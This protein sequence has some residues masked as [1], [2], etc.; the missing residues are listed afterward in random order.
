MDRASRL[1]LGAMIEAYDVLSQLQA[2]M[3]C[4]VEENENIPVLRQFV[5]D[6]NTHSQT[7]SY[8]SQH[9]PQQTEDNPLPV[10]EMTADKPVL[11]NTDITVEETL[12]EREG[13]CHGDCQ[14][15]G[16]GHLPD[17]VPAIRSDTSS[18]PDLVQHSNINN[19]HCKT[20][21]ISWRPKRSRPKFRISKPLEVEKV[22]R[23]QTRPNISWKQAGV[24]L[25]ELADNFSSVELSPEDRT[26]RQ[27]RQSVD[28]QKT[29]TEH[30][31]NNVF[32]C[33]QAVGLFLIMKKI[34]KMLK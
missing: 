34:D 9:P 13:D 1:L 6:I 20:P 14:S 31:I 4:E 19:S 28:G 17:I 29:D 2:E 25:S 27:V 3:G 22:R 10:H 21:K 26:S 5:E 7:I 23:S 18:L 24:K 16:V 11:T 30:L 8:L 15:D 32:K 33:I 12:K